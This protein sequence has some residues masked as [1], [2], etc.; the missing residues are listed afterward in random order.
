MKRA[1]KSTVRNFIRKPVINLINL[2]GLA[3]SLALVIILSGYCYSELTTDNFHKNGDRIYFYGELNNKLYTPAILKETID[4]GVPG[5]EATVRIAG[6]WETPVFQ[7]GNNE[8]INSDIL[9]ADKDFFKL[10]TYQA[11]EGNLESALNEPLSIIITNSL[12]KKLFGESRAVGKTI[13][14]NNGKEL[15]VKAVIKVPQENSCLSFNAVTSINTRK[16]IEPN[17]GE[18]TLWGWNSFQTFLLLKEGTNPKETAK[19]ILSVIPQNEQ[20]NYANITPIPF[21]SIYFSKFKL[22]DGNYLR[23]GSKSGIMILLMVAVLV[24]FIALVNFINIAS[25]Q[26]IDKIK[27]TGVMKIIGAKRSTIIRQILSEALL[28]FFSSFII[29]LIIVKTAIPFIQNY[30]GISFSNSLVF[31]PSFLL[32]AI[33]AT[34]FLSITFSIIPALGISSSKALDNLKKSINHHSQRSMLRGILVTLQFVIAIV[35]IAFTILVQKQVNFGSNMGFKQNNTIGIKLTEELYKKKE[36]LRDF[37]QAIPN[38]KMISFSQYYPG[39]TISCWGT[40]LEINGSKKEIWFDTF[41]ADSAFFGI[42]GLN[43]TEGRFYSD[44]LATD[45]AKIVVNESFIKTF[46]LTSPVGVKIRGFNGEFM[47]I[48]GV[49]KDFHHKPINQ[50]IVPLAIRNGS[51]ASYCMVNLQTNDFSSLHKTLTEIKSETTKLSPDA[52]VEISFLDQAV[53]NMY[54]AELRFR[55]TFSLFAVSAI[56]ICCMGILAISLFACQQRTK[57]I[58]IRKVNGARVTEILAMLN[59][60]FIKWVAVAFVIACPIAWYVMNKW[61]QNF[62][63]KTALSWWVFVLAGLTAVAVALLTVSWQSWRAAIKNP[64]ESLRYE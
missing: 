1:L 20:K 34:F 50:P 13:K 58:G 17:E 7:A 61:L 41:C 60:D 59:Q 57:E 33:L 2:V 27:Q 30:T 37:L 11:L 23:C 47:E 36:V 29:G 12:A 35:L 24:L 3:I 15:T 48:A 6:S 22:F 53:E 55:R 54:Q 42:M 62:A 21:K 32:V 44:K 46:G 63:Y 64:V 9:F 39:K 25:S 56:V 51:S 40:Q 4:Q 26:W 43:T 14:Y 10:F 28:V 52:P 5:I 8:P 18:F 38:T 31:S 49:I 45:A 19:R 16:I